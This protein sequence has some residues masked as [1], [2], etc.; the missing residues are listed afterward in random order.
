MK[1]KTLVSWSSGKDSAWALH[2]ARQNPSMEIEG[3]FTVVNERFNRISMHGVRIELLSIQAD[4][5]GLP[6]KIIKIPDP[7]SDLQYESIMKK[8]IEDERS[9]GVE[10]LVFGDISLL[11]VRNYRE[12]QLKGTGIFP[13]FPLW[14]RPG[15]RLVKEMLSEGLKAIITCIDSRKLSHPYAGTLLTTDIIDE[16]PEM[17][18]P[19]GE[20]GEYHTFVVDGPM[21]SRPIDVRVGEIVERDGLIFADLL[22]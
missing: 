7:C 11:D 18:D 22:L 16:L 8:F 3:I 17:V 1:V 5:I 21:F 10:C 2:L 6:L 13:I 20:N 12:N 19:C 14:G 9:D 15:R 4:A